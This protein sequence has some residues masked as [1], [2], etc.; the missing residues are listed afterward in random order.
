MN[1][2]DVVEVDWLYTAQT[3]S[4]LRPA[5]IVQGDFLNGLIDDTILLQITG[6]RH[7]IPNTEVPIDPA[8]ETGS[9]L[10]KPCVVSCP[11]IMTMDQALI[12]RVIGYLSDATMQKVED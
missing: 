1:R 8:I 10:S 12:L 5:V 4:K 3:G 9:G 6:T 2:G 11:N 7:H